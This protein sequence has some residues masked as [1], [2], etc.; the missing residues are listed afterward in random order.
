MLYVLLVLA[1]I[2]L[3]YINAKRYRKP[4]RVDTHDRQVT[5]DFN[6]YQITVIRKVI[7]L[8]FSKMMGQ[9]LDKFISF[10]RLDH[11]HRPVGN[12]LSWTY[13]D[14]Q[15][16]YDHKGH[17]KNRDKGRQNDS[18]KSQISDPIGWTQRYVQLVNH[19][20]VVQHSARTSQMTHL[21]E[22]GHLIPHW[23][24][25]NEIMQRNLMPIPQYTNKGYEGSD[26]NGLAFGKLNPESMLYVESNVK[27]FLLSSGWRQR[28]HKGDT[29]QMYVQ[30]KYD[31]S[32]SYVPTEIVY[33]FQ[34]V[35]AN[36]RLRSFELFDTTVEVGEILQVIVP[37]EMSTGDLV[38]IK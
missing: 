27:E 31:V 25:Q 28:L 22:R 20:F 5:I 2:A 3:I 24:S 13:Q 7:D 36:G 17:F 29:F 34:I 37:V 11:L 9:R 12:L 26:Q 18:Q 38:S 4:I 16:W 23:A 35:S 10:D 15:D 30:P 6:K 14:S 21:F 33:S 32:N 19:H 1:V 8:K